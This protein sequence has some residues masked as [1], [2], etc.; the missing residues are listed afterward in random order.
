MHRLRHLR[1]GLP[2]KRYQSGIILTDICSVKKSEEVVPETGGNFFFFVFL[3]H[4]THRFYKGHKKSAALNAEA[5]KAAAWADWNSGSALAGY[6]R[7]N[8]GFVYHDNGCGEWWSSSYNAWKVCSAN[9]TGDIISFAAET[10]G[11][12]SYLLSV[13]CI[14]P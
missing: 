5:D 12:Q 4:R 9:T 13:R 14:K 3:P 7:Y 11:S 2:F 8:Q 1:C 6:Y 10:Y